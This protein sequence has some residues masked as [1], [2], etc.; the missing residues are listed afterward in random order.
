[1]SKKKEK[2]RRPDPVRCHC[3]AV[4]VKRD[5]SYI[6]GEANWGG[7]LYVCSRYPECDSYVSADKVN[8]LPLGT[9]ANAR[10]RHMRIE[11]HRL[12]D[13]IWENGIMTRSSA[14]HWICDKYGLRRSEAHIAN[15]SEHMCR[16]LMSDCQRMLRNNRIAC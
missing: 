8:G 9:L 5:G 11:T 10:L 4:A 12:F 6:H 14:Y 15:F 2:R 3:G 16:S 1:M 13:Q 7:D